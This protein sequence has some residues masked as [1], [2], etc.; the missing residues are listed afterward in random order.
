MCNDLLVVQ[1]WESCDKRCYVSV[2][3]T[4]SVS[5]HASLPRSCTRSGLRYSTDNYRTTTVR[6]NSLSP[7]RSWRRGGG[8]NV[9]NDSSQSSSP[10]YVSSKN[11][12]TISTQTKEQRR[13]QRSL[14]N[15]S[16]NCQ[17]AVISQSGSHTTQLHCE[18]VLSSSS[19]QGSRYL[20]RSRSRSPTNL[21]R[22]NVSSTADK[23]IS[24]ELM[25][26][27]NQ[28]SNAV[29]KKRSVTNRARAN[30]DRTLKQSQEVTDC[31]NVNQS[32]SS[33]WLPNRSRSHSAYCIHGNNLSHLYGKF[34]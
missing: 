32:A 1:L 16:S 3:R 22:S 25:C 27:L 5:T 12:S 24:R 20:S 4:E 18:A 10:T 21:R 8:D 29:V 7:T 17:S 13:I 28:S 9:S 19:S 33:S 14:A 30:T 31:Q 26:Q 23:S 6:K 2:K 15:Q 34:A 11:K